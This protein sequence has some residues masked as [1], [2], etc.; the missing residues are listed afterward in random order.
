MPR[1]RRTGGRGDAPRTRSLSGPDDL[2]PD[3]VEHAGG[4]HPAGRAPRA[5]LHE[6]RRFR[7]AARSV[8][9]R[10]PGHPAVA[11][12]ISGDRQRSLRGEC[13]VVP[14]GRR[15]VGV[16]R[17]SV[18]STG[19]EER[20][21]GG[22]CDASS[23]RDSRQRKR[24]DGPKSIRTGQKAP[25]RA[26]A[27][28]PVPGSRAMNGQLQGAYA[29]SRRRRCRIATSTTPMPAREPANRSRPQ[30]AT[31]GTGPT[32]CRRTQPRFEFGP[33]AGRVLK[34]PETSEMVPAPCTVR[35]SAPERM[36]ISGD[37]FALGACLFS[38]APARRILHRRDNFEPIQGGI[39]ERPSRQAADGG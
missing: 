31:A 24:P 38:D 5:A 26:D 14:P 37:P 18:R 15:E 22:E 10:G 2:A 35:A 11:S 9:A 39:R 28:R 17:A 4:P 23:G 8:A 3:R 19:E 13:L 25:G 7:V 34:A 1:G 33:D 32:S 27:N 20:R 6:G 21:R 12:R 36:K 29:A 16:G 30:S